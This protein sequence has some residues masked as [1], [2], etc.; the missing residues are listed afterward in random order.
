MKDPKKRGIKPITSHSQPFTSSPSGHILGPGDRAK[1]M[2]WSDIAHY[3]ARVTPPGIQNPGNLMRDLRN[4]QDGKMYA[5]DR[6]TRQGII[7]AE[8]SAPVSSPP[9]HIVGQP[10]KR[11]PRSR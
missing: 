8:P 10:K 5:H 1:Q 9:G 2:F 6:Y 3:G 4:K 7:P 11:R